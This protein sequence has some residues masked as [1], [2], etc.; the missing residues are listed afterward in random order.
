ME[1]GFLS[2]SDRTRAVTA[3]FRVFLATTQARG[4]NG[5][6]TSILIKAL[7]RQPERPEYTS[8]L[9]NL[10]NE[11]IPPVKLSHLVDA[12]L[13]VRIFVIY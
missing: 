9:E 12:F 1:Y 4:A 11:A 13:L 10:R 8:L 3:N 6:D 7:L 5:A 2:P